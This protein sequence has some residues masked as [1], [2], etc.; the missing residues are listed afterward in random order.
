M[1]KNLKK[2]GDIIK[3]IKN[4]INLYILLYTKNKNLG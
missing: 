3:N 4:T 2:P 1:T